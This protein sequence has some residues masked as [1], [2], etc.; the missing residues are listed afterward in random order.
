MSGIVTLTTDFGDGDGYV[1]E[2]KGALLSLNP[3][4]TIVDVTH[5]IEPQDIRHGAYVIG[6]VSKRFP[7]GT[8]HVAVVDPGVGTERKQ[9][10]VSHETGVFIGPDN[11]LLTSILTAPGA[12]AIHE[13]LNPGLT[14]S[15]VSRTF[16]GRDIF[17]PAAAH[18]SLGVEIGRFG[19]VVP[20]PI[21]LREW[22]P[23]E[24]KT[25]IC[26]HVVHIDRFG[27]LITNIGS[28]MMEGKTLERIQIGGQ[29][30]VELSD[31]YGDVETG[32]LVALIGSQNT[33]EISVNGEN[34]A[35]MLDAGRGDR[36]TIAWRQT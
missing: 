1:A 26:G 36:V 30:L 25:G 28:G 7:L 2:M 14:A 18:L 27:S 20:D 10:I 29:N 24:T 5:A 4:L 19:P 15:W 11:G 22:E 34:A 8:V 32:K 3:D 6:T 31:A 23:E 13:I 17:A 35:K 9:L 12:K 21:L 33:L 16:H